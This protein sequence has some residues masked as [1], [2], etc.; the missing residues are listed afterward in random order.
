MYCSTFFLPRMYINKEKFNYRISSVLVNPNNF[1]EKM[2]V[3][4]DA[5]SYTDK[6]FFTNYSP[7]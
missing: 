6:H 2:C 3:R 7:N 4:R 5:K 1:Y